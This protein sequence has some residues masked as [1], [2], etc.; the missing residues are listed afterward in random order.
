MGCGVVP[1]SRI[2]W[3]RALVI[4][5]ALPKASAYTTPWYDPSGWVSSGYFPPALQSKE[6]PST[7]APPTTTAWPSMYFVDEWTTMSA[8]C[9]N[10][11]QRMGVANVLST[12]RGTPFEW[13]RAEKRSKSKTAS[14]GLAIVS[15]K[16]ALVRSSKRAR[17]S[18]SLIVGS[19]TLASIP[20]RFIVTR[21]RFVVPP[22]RLPIMMKLSPAEAMLKREM[23]EAA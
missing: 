18:S 7:I 23:N 22:Y 15:P 19:A 21:K 4:Y 5:A 10:G 6:P 17:I 13:A 3:V 14:E 8:P 20:I 2:S 1:R 11:R 12:M 16:K 9:S